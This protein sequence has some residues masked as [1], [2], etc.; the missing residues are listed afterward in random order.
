MAVLRVV[1]ECSGLEPLPYILDQL[2]L[3]NKYVIEAACEIDPLCRKV[4]ELCHKGK[5]RPKRMLTDITKRAPAELPDHDVYVAG[6]PCQP[7]SVMGLQQGMADSKGRGIIIKHIVAALQHKRPKAFVLE[8][9]RGLL[10]PRHE[11]TFHLIMCK[12]RSIASNGYIVG[13]KVLDTADYGLPQHRERVYIV[14]ILRSAMNP[15]R[16][17]KWPAPRRLVPLRKCLKWHPDWLQEES[18]KKQQNL[19]LATAPPKLK[20][21]L[22]RVLHQIRLSGMDPYSAEK[23]LV[24]DIDAST[25]RWMQGRSPCL[26]RA[27]AATG[28]YFPALGRRMSIQERL[29][30]QGLPEAIYEKCRDKITERQLGQMVGNSLSVNVMVALLR[31]IFTACGLPACK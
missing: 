23:P 18:R 16:P 12:L 27:R 31:N 25:P 17:F 21:R 10:A 28:H 13:Y 11:K 4:I 8:N 6:F 22:Q 19:F 30:L 2:G 20:Q 7:F 3:R 14:G 15:K 29:R 24:A 1:T 9:V 26:T 5:A